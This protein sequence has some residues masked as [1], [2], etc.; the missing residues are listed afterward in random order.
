MSVDFKSIYNYDL[1]EVLSIERFAHQI[2]V[3]DRL[4]QCQVG[5]NRDRIGSKSIKNHINSKDINLKALC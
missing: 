4:C 3:R 1:I 2:K 5:L